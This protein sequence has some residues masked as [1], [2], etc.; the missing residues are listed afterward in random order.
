MKTLLAEEVDL[1]TSMSAIIIHMYA[2]N[3]RLITCSLHFGRVQFMPIVVHPL[4]LNIL[5]RGQTKAFHTSRSP[6]DTKYQICRCYRGIMINLS[7]FPL[8]RLVVLERKS[9]G[10][11]VRTRLP[12]DPAIAAR[13]Q[14]APERDRTEEAR[15]D[16]SQTEGENAS[17]SPHA[18]AIEG[19]YSMED[20]GYGKRREG[21]GCFRI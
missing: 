17:L 10:A 11:L 13:K 5:S 14:N 9:T 8:I 4:S 19:V 3:Q 20:S 18:V 6:F 21:V 1:H 2:P 12:A 7:A 16:G 15:A